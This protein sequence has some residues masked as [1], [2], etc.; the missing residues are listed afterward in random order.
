M[1]GAKRAARPA[2]R[3]TDMDHRK[4]INW[5]VVYRAGN[6]MEADIIKGLLESNGIR[7]SINERAIPKVLPYEAIGNIPVMVPSEDAHAAL[8]LIRSVE[9][10]NDTADES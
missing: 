10:E 6:S 7:C 4:E 9:K 8:E 2:E 5:F 1:C 3:P